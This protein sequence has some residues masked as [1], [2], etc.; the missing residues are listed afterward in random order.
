VVVIDYESGSL[1]MDRLLPY[2]KWRKGQREIAETIY[3][4]VRD[5]K[6]LLLGYPTG[7]GKTIAALI[8]TY[9]AKSK[10]HKIFFLARTKNQVQA[11]LREISRIREKGVHIP[12][13]VLQNKRDMCPLAIAKRLS[14]DEFLRYCDSLL[15]LGLCDYYLNLKESENVLEV[16]YDPEPSKFVEKFSKLGLCPYEIAKMLVPKSEIIIGSYLY[17]F[18][19]EIRYRLQSSTGLKLEDLVLIID[20]AHNLPEIIA[21]MQSIKL[22]KH[23]VKLAQREARKFLFGEFA[24]EI[25]TSLSNTYSYIL[26]LEKKSGGEDYLIDTSELLSVMPSLS[27]L[28]KAVSIVERNM[29]K[30]GILAPSNMA[31]I[32]ELLKAVQSTAHGFILYS[33]STLEGFMVKYQCV[34][35]SIAAREV[36]SRVHAAVLMSGTLQPRDYMVSM[37]A[38][39]R[40]R[41]V[42]HRVHADFSKQVKLVVHSGIS[43]RYVERS[44]ENFRRIAK[45]IAILFEKFDNGVMLAVFPSYDFMKKVNAFLPSK[46]RLY[47]FIE[48]EDT[49]LSQV[50][51]FVEQRSKSLVFAAAWGK[52]IEGIELRNELS[53]I[54]SVIVAGLPVP[55]PS[56]VN[57]KREELLTARFLD[58]EKAWRFI[59]IIPA[60]IRV[61]Q[62]I[63]RAVRTE[64][65]KAFVAVLDRR[66]LENDAKS[67][68]EIHG[69]HVKP[70][71][72]LGQILNEM[73]SFW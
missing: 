27:Q 3:N 14:Y 59:Y 68:V 53:L 44:E 29:V 35:P 65:D 21:D 52:L 15:K 50:E 5:R 71:D 16:D 11:P 40:G 49:T 34:D 51:E 55:E 23:Q 31:R 70:V 33:T 32:L 13:V 10:K 69:Y 41:V 4:T 24:E 39:E 72:S 58:E 36:F 48:R 66:L 17:I 43:S 9:M 19:K 62:A 12:T 54:K 47:T 8:G 7:A 25:L 37:L 61:L 20:E 46:T 67:L 22:Y 45:I 1:S 56:L 42:E 2:T 60:V 57:V 6:I 38:L 30:S 28:K 18:S 63:G 73:T 64:R 26:T